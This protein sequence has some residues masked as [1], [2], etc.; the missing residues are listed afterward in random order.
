MTQLFK[1]QLPCWLKIR[2]PFK[3]QGHIAQIILLHLEQETLKLTI[4]ELPDQYG[5]VWVRRTYS[6][7]VFGSKPWPHI[8]PK[9][10]VPHPTNFSTKLYVHQISLSPSD[11]IGKKP[12][13]IYLGKVRS[14]VHSL[15]LLP[16]AYRLMLSITR[17]PCA[18]ALNR[19]TTRMQ[20][21]YV[22]GQETSGKLNEPKNCFE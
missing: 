9:P 18:I 10:I 17:L 6:W 19:Q 13:R 4:T 7:G 20:I 1:K 8:S 14:F 12:S 21:S 5:W 22:K 11:V 3:R 16:V 15:R 2:H